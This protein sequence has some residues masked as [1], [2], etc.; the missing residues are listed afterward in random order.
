MR[1]AMTRNCDYSV[2]RN[3]DGTF[4]LTRTSGPFPGTVAFIKP[5]LARTGDPTGWQLKPLVTMHGAKSKI[6]ETAAEAIAS[7]KLMT[8]A[9][10]KRAVAHASGST[11]K[12]VT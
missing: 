10:A 6:W 5:I 12:G 11:G 9:A 4:S 1:T 3:T 8:L 7:T 2:A